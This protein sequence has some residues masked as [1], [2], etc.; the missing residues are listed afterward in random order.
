MSNE[1]RVSQRRFPGS[2]SEVVQPVRLLEVCAQVPV[3]ALVD[4]LKRL[5]WNGGGKLAIRLGA[6]IA[7]AP[8]LN[9]LVAVDLVPGVKNLIQ[10]SFDVCGVP[11]GVAGG[12]VNFGA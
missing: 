12:S 1:V 11:S 10:P 7:E 4:R 2:R 9:R 6:Q 5:A 8:R 3:E